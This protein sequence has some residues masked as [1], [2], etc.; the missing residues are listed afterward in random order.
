MPV[1]NVLR[2]DE[3]RDRRHSRRQLA[4]ALHAGDPVRSRVLPHLTSIAE[5][6]GSD[7]VAVV[8]VD[9]FA[10]RLAHPWLV[11]DLLSD[12]PRRGFA[13]DPL[14]RAWERGIPGK[15]EPLDPG[16]LTRTPGLWIALG[17][18]G[19][20]GWFVVADTV[21]GRAPLSEDQRARTMFLAGECSAI[22]LH[23]DLDTQG[24]QGRPAFPGHRYLE[25]LEGSEHREDRTDEATRRFIV[26]RLAETLLDD[27][28]SITIERAKDGAERARAELARLD[29]ADADESAVLEGVIHAYEARNTVRLS[30]AMMRLGARSEARGHLHG[31]RAAFEAGFRLAAG[32]ADAVSAVNAARSLGR[33]FRR[34]ADW[35][36][37]DRWYGQALEIAR[38]AGLGDLAARSLSGLGLVKRDL[39]NLPGAR[40]RFGEALKLAEAAGEWDA[41]ASVHHDLMGLEQMAGDYGQ[42]LRHGWRAANTYTTELQRTRCMASLGGVL[43][44]SGSLQ[45]AEDAFSV[46]ARQSG[47]QYYLLYAADA[48]GH[49][50]ALRGD[51]DA[52]ERLSSRCD[53]LGWEDGPPYVKAEILCFRGLSFEALG[54]PHDARSWLERAVEWSE[55]HG[56]NRILF[57]SEEALARLDRNDRR[58]RSPEPEVGAFSAPSEVSEGLRALRLELVGVG[59]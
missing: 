3:Y 30:A 9:E 44:E 11:L 18:D 48:L 2:L 52:F 24:T 15:E 53:R 8:W 40:E 59:A 6:S 4:Q 57:K 39:G 58:S 22:V 34:A 51:H 37:A 36:T 32:L 29:G 33:L 45:A 38:V 7:R 49:I 10:P 31:A 14:Q 25:D 50:A 56:F 16:A 27:D 47:E 54:R 42:A 55:A 5:I 1:A 41:L 21:T 13:V 43:L 35:E 46:V 20:R 23:R 28:G 19:A 26:G 17:S 12:R